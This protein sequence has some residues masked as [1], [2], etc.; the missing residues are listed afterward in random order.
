MQQFD[1]LPLRPLAATTHCEDVQAPTGPWST[2]ARV[3]VG[4]KRLPSASANE[5]DRHIG[6]GPQPLRGIPGF[7]TQQPQQNRNAPLGAGRLPNGKLGSGSS[8]GFGVPMGGAPGL[9]N[10]QSRPTSAAMTSFAQT[11]G[12]SQPATPLDL[13]EFP[14]LSGAPQPQHQNPAQAVWANANQRASQHTPVQRPQQQQHANQQLSSVQPQPQLQQPQQLSQPQSQHSNDDLFPSSAQF[15]NGLDDYRHGGQSGVGQLS[16]LIQP[17]TGNIEEFPPLSRNGNGEIGQDRRGGLI[18]NA[19]F[20]GY[21]NGT[22]FG[23]NL[24]QPQSLQ[25]RFGRFN[26]MNGQQEN[27]R[28]SGITDRIL[29]PSLHGSGGVSASRTPLDPGRQGKVGPS[30]QENHHGIRLP[31]NGDSG[32][33]IFAS[34]QNSQLGAK[35]HAF[36]EQPPPVQMQPP[37]QPQQ[38]SRQQQQGGFEG[39]VFDSPGAVQT[40]EQIP[41][42]QMSE[43]DRYGLAGLLGVIRHDSNDVAGLAVG[44]DLTTLGLDLN[45]P[46]N[47]PLYHNFASPF[48]ESGS[49]PIQ[50]DFTV[51]ACYTVQNVQP[52]QSKVPSFSDE[53]LLYIFYTMPRDIMQEIVAQE[54]TNRNWRYH[55]ELKQWL[56]KDVSYPEPTPISPEAERGFYVFFD[57]SLWQRTRREFILHYDSLDNRNSRS[58]P[59]P[60]PA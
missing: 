36:S 55:K 8:W 39:D 12:G 22:G 30:E 1:R 10:P 37:S 17:Q 9:P 3:L 33:S 59:F 57:P 4:N 25:N 50:P 53:T 44:Q 21:A 32:N 24:S 7:P 43:L 38:Q 47:S 40:P 28:F 46:D 5:R 2:Y 48:A 29:S 51:P 58:L 27:S 31:Q 14:S 54:L 23:T 6:P 60:N 35:S 41:L 26:V 52:L 45:Q 16:G 13:S 42:S 15:T 56:T 11:I 19:A 18:Q 49:R 20:G 34:M